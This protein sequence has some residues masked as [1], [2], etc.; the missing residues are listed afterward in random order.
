MDIQMN[1]FNLKKRLLPTLALACLAPFAS[2]NALAAATFNS[3]A[4]VTYTITGLTNSTTPGDFSGLNS[5]SIEGTF[6]LAP[7]QA[8]SNIS[9]DGAVTPTL[10]GAG[11][12][13]LTPAI[14]SSYSRTFQLDG[15]ANN[16]GLVSANY[17]SWFGLAFQNAS[18]S[19]SY[20]VDL[21][22]AYTLSA[23]A[24]G[25]NAFSDVTLNYYN[26]DE[27]YSNFDAPGYIQASTGTLG[28]AYLQNSQAFSFFLAPDGFESLYV[29]AGITA[30]LEAAP[31]SIPVPPAFWLFSSALLAIPGLKKPRKAA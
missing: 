20:N 8:F 28:T 19:D 9:G 6:D 26:A 2:Q 21:T 1:S 25:D 3:Y 22:M 14:G 17:L 27:S 29:D 16:G 15:E 18:T 5:G 12:T 30:T 7:G 10:A 4:T 31:A 24:T 11:S 13:F 23:Q